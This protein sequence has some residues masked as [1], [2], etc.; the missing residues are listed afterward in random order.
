MNSPTG[1]LPLPATAQDAV[2]CPRC[3]SGRIRYSAPKTILDEL[4]SWIGRRPLRCHSCYHRWR[5]WM[6]R[7]RLDV[8]AS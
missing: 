7:E 5:Q 6:S 3:L 8:R 1:A 4:L 2:K